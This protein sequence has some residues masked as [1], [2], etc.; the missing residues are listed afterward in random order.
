MDWP[1]N[2]AA[3]YARRFVVEGRYGMPDIVI[4]PGCSRLALR[5]NFFVNR[6]FSEMEERRCQSE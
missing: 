5:C 6:P 3:A 4:N 2:K 1:Q